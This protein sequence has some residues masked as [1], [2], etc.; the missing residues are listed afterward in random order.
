MDLSRAAGIVSLVLSIPQGFAASFQIIDRIKAKKLQ[1]P[2]ISSRR[3]WF[4]PT[5]LLVGM[6]VCIVFGCWILFVD[7]FH[8]ITVEKPVI[9]EKPSPCP[10]C[11]VCPATKTGAAIAKSG[12]G[13]TS[14]AHSG[15]GDIYNVPPV[16][17]PPQ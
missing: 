14:T 5:L 17:N 9:V 12:K 1:A 13:G 4:L 3:T 6:A 8:P 10:A 11:P 15:N 2:G 7:P 16:A